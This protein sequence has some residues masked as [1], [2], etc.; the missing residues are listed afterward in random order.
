[1]IQPD[2]D[3]ITR[4]QQNLTVMQHCFKLSFVKSV[5]N[6]QVVRHATGT[7]DKEKDRLHENTSAVVLQRDGAI[8]GMRCKGAL[9]IMSF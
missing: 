1:M 6:A 9:A 3:H 8:E 2:E 7:F 4:G 5:F